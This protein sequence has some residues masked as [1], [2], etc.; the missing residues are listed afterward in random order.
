[1]ATINPIQTEAIMDTSSQIR[2]SCYVKLP[3]HEQIILDVEE[4]DFQLINDQWQRVTTG[5]VKE[6]RLE[7]L[8]YGMGWEEHNQ[9]QLNHIKVRGFRKDGG[10]RHRDQYLNNV[11]LT[12]SLMAQIPDSFHDY[13]RQAFAEQVIELQK[14]LTE[15]NNNGV[16]I[17]NK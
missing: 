10:L 16:K 1:M 2:F 17:D 3:E 12:D 14:N 11:D 13:A 8:Q 9:V 5:V 4:T 15:L 6:Y 7:E